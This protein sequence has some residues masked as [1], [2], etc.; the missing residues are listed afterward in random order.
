MA[1]YKSEAIK[2]ITNT[3]ASQVHRATAVA[4]LSE[5]IP[6]EYL[7]NNNTIILFY[8]VLFILIGASYKLILPEIGPISEFG[9]TAI[10]WEAKVQ[11]VLLSCEVLKYS[12]P[13]DDVIHSAIC[14]VIGRVLA[15]GENIITRI[16][17]TFFF[18]FSFVLCISFVIC[19]SFLFI[20]YLFIY[21]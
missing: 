4:V 18:S 8:Y 14:D 7:L 15:S 3:D 1:I 12:L 5:I 9:E 20:L 21:Y 17:G 6:F 19:T 10:W 11:V 13:T 2:L 16:L